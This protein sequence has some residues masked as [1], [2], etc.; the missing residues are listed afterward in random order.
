[1][2]LPI[3]PE[4]IT[5]GLVGV[6][7]SLVVAT[8]QQNWKLRVFFLLALRLAIGWHFLFEGLHKIHSHVVGPTDTT[9]PFTSEP[10]FKAS[11]TRIGA[12]MRKEF[13]NPAAVI[14]EYLTPPKPI[15]PEAF[16]QLSADDQAA[17]CPPFVA[18]QFDALKEKA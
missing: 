9:R 13:E 17:A 5:A 12:E 14:A 8:Y 11:P 3:P 15:T 1:M 6:V 7:L 18:R 10:Y 16:R 4:V 2:D